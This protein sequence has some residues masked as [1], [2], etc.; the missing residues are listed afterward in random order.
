MQISSGY[1]LDT[2]ERNSLWIIRF[3]HSWLLYSSRCPGRSAALHSVHLFMYAATAFVPFLLRVTQ[4]WSDT[5]R[6]MRLTHVR[7]APVSAQK[8]ACGCPYTTTRRCPCI[9]LTGSLSAP[10][11]GPWVKEVVEHLN[12]KLWTWSQQLRNVKCWTGFIQLIFAQLYNLAL[13]IIN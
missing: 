4:L 7:V 3:L 2:T 12:F 9:A 10:G 11:G 8:V 6:G 5:S 13:W 1:W